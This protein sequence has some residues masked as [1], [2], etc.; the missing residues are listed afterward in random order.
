MSELSISNVIRVTVQGVQR[1]IGVK[2]INEVA[3]FT[4]EAANSIDP[5]FICYDAASVAKI[6]GS[7][8]LTYKMALNVFAQDANPLSGRGYLVVIPMSATNATSASFTT[9]AL[10][11]ANFKTISDGSLTITADGGTSVEVTGLDFSSVA[12]V[13]DIAA[14]LSSKISSCAISVSSGSLV[15]T[16]KKLGSASSVVLTSGTTGTDLAGSDY[17]NISEGTT[18]NGANSSGETLGQAIERTKNQVRYCGIISAL[19]LEDSAVATAAAVVQ[20]GD[21]I[22]VNSWFSDADIAGA[23]TTVKNASQTHVRCLVYT[24]GKEK[25]KLYE[26]A[27]TGRAFSVNF[28][29][30]QVSQ[31]MNL[32]TL[33]NVTPDSGISQNAYTAAKS[34]GVDLYVSYEGF[35]AVLSSGGNTYFDVV[36]ENMAFK[37]YAQNYMI[38][39]LRATNTKIP[40]TEAGVAVLTNALAQAFILFVRNGVFAAGKW[41]SSQTFGDPETFR[42]NIAD[43]GWYI[44]H[45]PIAQQSQAEREARVAPLIQGAGKR[46]GAVHEADVLIIVEE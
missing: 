20:A 45:T 8:S 5:Y 34:A 33:A 7:S 25:A 23:C 31:T 2:N 37:F 26:A 9:P 19:Y 11:V 22:W 16:S 1:S 15:F 13:E 21:F 3:L 24:D 6:F 39:A 40:Q 14:V 38:N 30:S 12:T 27:Y 29:G 32:K 36:Y 42:A 28:E 41:N 46:A 43:Q 44:Y 18:A 17:L 10:T 35:P 4:P